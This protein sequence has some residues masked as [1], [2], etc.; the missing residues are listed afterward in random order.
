MTALRY[1]ALPTAEV[2]ALRAGRPDAYGMTPERTVSDGMGNPCRHCLRMIPEGAGMLILAHRPFPGPGPY[3]ET[4][5]VFLCADACPRHDEATPPGYLRFDA[6]V[7]GYLG[8]DRIHYGTGAV[9][10]PAEV[11][12]RCADLLADPANAYVHVRSGRN[13]CFQ[14]RVE[15]A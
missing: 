13:G 14:F 8:D 1:L 3:A 10:P 2:E 5:P 11:P 4:G 6:L 15:R 12:A 9:I 7:T